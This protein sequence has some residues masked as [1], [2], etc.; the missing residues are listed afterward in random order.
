[1]KMAVESQTPLQEAER[2]VLS[3]RIGYPFYAVEQLKKEQPKKKRKV[4]GDA[5]DE[6]DEEDEED[7][8]DES[9]I[10]TRKAGERE[11]KLLQSEQDQLEQINIAWDQVLNIANKVAVS[12]RLSII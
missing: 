9:Q 4:G 2:L 7:V 6:G 8:A 3:K 5:D 12:C 1:M 10:R 11:G